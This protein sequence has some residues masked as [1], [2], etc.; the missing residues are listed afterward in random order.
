MTEELERLLEGG[1]VLAR[2]LVD[3]L[4]TVFLLFE[5]GGFLAVFY[6]FADGLLF[7]MVEPKLL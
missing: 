4:F 5:I 3:E 2:L 7:L 1:R 6:V